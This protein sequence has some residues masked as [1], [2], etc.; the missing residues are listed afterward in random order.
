MATDYL[1][2]KGVTNIVFDPFQRS[3][4]HNQKAVAAIKN[5]QADTAT[6]ANVL[7]VI[8]DPKERAK[9]IRRAAN[10]VGKTGVAYFQ[11]HEGDGDGKSRATRDGWQEYRKLASYMPEIEKYFRFVTR[12]KGYI[13]A[14]QEG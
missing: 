14:R 7:N 11:V 6:V 13:E 5:G 9:T 10:A 12:T 3:D 8:P 2:E 1:K 4:E